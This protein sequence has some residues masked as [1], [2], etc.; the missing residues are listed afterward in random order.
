MLPIDLE[1]FRAFG[2]VVLHGA[3][4]PRPLEMEVEHALHYGAPAPLKTGVAEM[5]YV[6]MMN[7]ATPRS[8]GMLD[9]FESVASALL[10]GPVIALRAKGVR[11]F[12]STA[13]HRDSADGAVMS[14]GFV[15]YL[16]ALSADTGALRVVPGSHRREI[17]D[18][19]V[20]SLAGGVSTRLPP[21]VPEVAVTTEPGDVIA[22]D[23]HLIHA[24]AGGAERR[25]W[26]VD[27][28][29]QP[30]SPDEEAASRVYVAR[31]FPPD[32]DGGYDP[33]HFPS[34][35]PDWLA[36]GRT[37]VEHLRS[38]GVYPLASKQEAFMRSRRTSS[39]TLPRV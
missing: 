4:D 14:I 11:Y 33:D 8:L 15:A 24:S 1:H 21:S 5:Q 17:G 39:T 28:L 12:G 16:E 2:F 30:R 18:A 6:P 29:R 13:W 25:Q 32:W 31:V 20:A 23:E 9:R 35:G 38:L 26:R 3:F 7:A 37:A 36:S 27:Y 19:V 22:L 34:Y 10:G